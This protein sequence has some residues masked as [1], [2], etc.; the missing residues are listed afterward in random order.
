M[1]SQVC[2]DAS[3]VLKLL[4]VEADS[5]KVHQL[6]NAWIDDGV[7]IVSPPLLAF[8]AT[9]VIRNK[10]YRS[11]I[12][13]EEAELMFKTFQLLSIRLRYPDNLH[14][15]A[16]DLAKYFNRPQAYDSHYLALAEIFGLEFWTSD[17]RLYHAVAS[18]LPWVK[19]LDDYQPA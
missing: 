11:L 4:L 5:A 17:E 6:W 1:N 10:M 7:E 13:P 16:W 12:L 9:S 2:V 14:Q 8:E 19:W 15:K 18:D 3:L